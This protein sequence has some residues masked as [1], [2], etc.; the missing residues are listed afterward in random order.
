MR[1]FFSQSHAF[2]GGRVA[3]E[4]T[5]AAAGTCIVEFGDGVTVI[6]EWHPADGGIRL[7]IPS[8]R[9]AKGTAVTARSWLL[10]QTGDGSWRSR[11]VSQG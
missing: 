1:F 10:Q 4:E 8:Y 6:G 9:T 5:G 7:D 2:P 3:V 11:R